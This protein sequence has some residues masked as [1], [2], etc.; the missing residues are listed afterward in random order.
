MC[1]IN[2]NKMDDIEDITP[3][4]KLDYLSTNNIKLRN[5]MKY[6]DVLIEIRNNMDDVHSQNEYENIY[7]TV[8]KNHKKMAK[9]CELHYLYRHLLLTNEI[10]T[11]ISFEEFNTT[12][13]NRGNSGVLVIAVM[14]SDKPNGQEFTCKWNCSYCPAEPNMPRSY[15]SN[16]PAVARGARNNFDPALQFN[17]RA[18]THFLNGHTVDKIELLILGGTFHSYPVDYRKN[19]IKM[20]IYSA[21]TFYDVDKREPLS[22]NEEV[23]I[24]ETSKVRIIGITI[25][26]R[27]DCINPNTLLEL[28]ELEVTRIQMGVQHTDDDVLSENNRGHKVK[29]S[30]R[31]IQ[32]AMDAGFKVDI[33]LMTNLPGAS[34]EKDKKMFEYVLSNPDIQG[35]QWK[36]YP[37]QVTPWTEIADKYNTGEYIPYNSNDMFEVIIDTM[38]KIWPWIR[39]NRIIRD[40]SSHD[41]LAGNIIPN[42]RQDLNNELAKRGQVCHDIRTREVRNDT[43]KIHLAKLVT[44]HIQKQVDYVYETNHT[45][46]SN[47]NDYF[48]SFESSSCDFCNTYYWHAI[49]GS[50][51]FEG[52]P[53]RDKIYA[54]LRLRIMHSNNKKFPEL[55]NR[56][57]AFIRELHVY[58]KITAVGQK[59]SN[60][61]VQHYHFGRCL[62]AAA[63][64]I[65]KEHNCDRIAI[66]S[67]LGVRKYYE[68][69]NYTKSEVGKYMIKDIDY[70]NDYLKLFPLFVLFI[71]I[72]IMLFGLL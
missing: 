63:E 9:K 68:K 19:F 11:N 64:K 50:D 60:D 71:S 34:A 70:S 18:T 42:M 40:F 6:K 67:G 47:H 36:I 56:K 49:R 46:T 51:K 57:I 27:P 10:K 72:F 32:M 38:S 48:L 4:S 2:N 16:E 23:I 30:I 3:P 61:G 35:D 53:N 15:I 22:F 12:K 54:F 66:I 44:R 25:E 7:I 69:F 59:K 21:N 20:L 65:A 31:G 55:Y 52:C 5:C 26:T 62:I 1:C 39:I 14:L 43:S 28:R 45:H 8:R 24:N 33:H 37:T 58:G 29:H 41:D 17:E 13:K